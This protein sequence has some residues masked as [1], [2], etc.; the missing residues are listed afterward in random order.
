VVYHVAAVRKIVTGQG[1]FITGLRAFWLD[2]EI[3]WNDSRFRK[4]DSLKDRTLVKRKLC[5]TRSQQLAEAD[6]VAL[7]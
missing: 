4:V 1:I 5:K 7:T 6:K 2:C 3:P